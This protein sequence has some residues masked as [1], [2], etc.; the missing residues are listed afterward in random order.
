MKVGNTITIVFTHSE[1]MHTLNSSVDQVVKMLNFQL[2]GESWNVTPR[3]FRY[4]TRLILT[5]SS[6]EGKVVLPFMTISLVLL[7]LSFIKFFTA[8]ALIFSTS[9]EA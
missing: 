1:Y 7:K 2:V 4:D 6:G 9:L 3:S 8:Q 5:I